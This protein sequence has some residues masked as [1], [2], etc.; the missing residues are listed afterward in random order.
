MFF[1]AY[2]QSGECNSRNACGSLSKIVEF[3]ED[4]ELLTADEAEM[5]G[6][7]SQTRNYITEYQSYRNHENDSDVDCNYYSRE[8]QNTKVEPKLEIPLERNFRKG[9]VG[10]LVTPSVTQPLPVTQERRKSIP[11]LNPILEK[12]GLQVTFGTQTEASE[13]KKRHSRSRRR[14]EKKP[15]TTSLKKE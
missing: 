3:D 15:L 8:S 10:D 12:K 13:P 6:L 2:S 7:D 11:K 9:A 1:H 14:N 5:R 4:I